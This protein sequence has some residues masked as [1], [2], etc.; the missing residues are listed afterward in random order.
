MLDVLRAFRAGA[1]NDDAARFAL[2]AIQAE[3]DGKLAPWA[4]TPGTRL[5]RAP[6]AFPRVAKP[7]QPVMRLAHELPYTSESSSGAGSLPKSPPGGSRR[8]WHCHW[9]SDPQLRRWRTE[10]GSSQVANSL[11]KKAF[12]GV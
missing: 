11:S 1:R 3:L 10:S 5:L 8:Y 7:L 12:L 4:G 2:E 6:V 9:H